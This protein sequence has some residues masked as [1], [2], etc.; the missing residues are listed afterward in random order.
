MAD[1]QHVTV[2]TGPECGTTEQVEEFLANHGIAYTVVDLTGKPDMIEKICK[3][4]DGKRRAPVIAIGD[5]VLAGFEPHELER[6][7]QKRFE[8]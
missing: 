2:Y 7:L 4:A 6:L 5:E 1:Q 3:K 8:K